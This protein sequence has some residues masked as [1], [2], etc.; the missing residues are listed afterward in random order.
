MISAKRRVDAGLWQK[1]DAL[2]CFSDSMT[3]VILIESGLQT[4]LENAQLP[5]F[6]SLLQSISKRNTSITIKS[7]FTVKH[8]K[9]AFYYCPMGYKQYSSQGYRDLYLCRCWG[10]SVSTGDILQ[11]L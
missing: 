10:V 3:I 4:A 6:P 1:T 9:S 5:A 7:A 11:Q 8:G 2:G